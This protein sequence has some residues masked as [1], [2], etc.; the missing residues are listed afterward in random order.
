MFSWDVTDNR[1]RSR[2]RRILAG[3]VAL[4][5][6]LVVG[7]FSAYAYRTAWMFGGFRWDDDPAYVNRIQV[8]KANHLK[9][10]VLPPGFYAQKS[11][12]PLK[13][14]PAAERK[15]KPERRR[16]EKP[17]KVV[18][19]EE[20]ETDVTAKAEAPPAPAPAPKP[21]GPPQ[22]GAIKE[23]ALKVHLKAIY[24]EYEKGN[25]PEDP[26]RV[27]V[28]CKVQQD[29]SLSDI[30][31]V[32]SSGNSMIDATA[33]NLFREISEMR[34]LQPLSVLS[35]LSLTLERGAAHSTISA[36][37]FSGDSE[38][39]NTLVTMLYAAKMAAQF[40][41]KNADQAALLQQLKI[42]QTGGRVSVS[43]GLPNSRAGDMMRKSFGTKSSAP[44]ASKATA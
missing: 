39:I 23:N 12:P 43:I 5:V 33:L 41:V 1:S 32:K 9:P 16:E 22:F 30:N 29:G 3:S 25:I 15:P 4:H 44:A 2:F 18:R 7:L 17:K 11:P 36:V 26:F 20:P 40:K 19:E 37:G 14:K 10:L 27:T 35:S 42:S 38:Q 8:A 34:A 6:A 31:V 13:E 28:T 24:A 21:S